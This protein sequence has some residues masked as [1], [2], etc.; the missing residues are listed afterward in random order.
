MIRMI[1]SKSAGHAKAY[2][3]EALAK[4]DYYISDQELA[5]V[6]QGKLATRLGIDGIVN[7]ES[8]FALCENRHPQTGESLTP[9]TKEDRTTGY[10]IN[11]HCPKS[12]SLLHVMSGNDTILKA[13]QDSV[14]E[15]MKEIERDAKTRVRKDGQYDDRD[16]RELV[17]AHFIHQTARPVESRAPD[18]HLHSHCFVFNATWDAQEQKIKAGQF[19]DI[20]RDMPYYQAV[21]H[22]VLSDRLVN[23]GYGIKRTQKSFE[24][25]G[26]AQEVID[27]FSKRTD[28]I[29]RIAKE[30]GITD[31]KELGELGARTR[32]KKQ[33]GTSMADLKKEWQEQIQIIDN[34]KY[35]N[36]VM[37]DKGKHLSNRGIDLTP[38]DCINHAL[39]HGFERASVMQDRRLLET[40]LRHSI[41]HTAVSGIAITNSF[42]SDKRLVRIKDKSKMLCTTK[43]VLSEE[44]RMVD[45]AK[46]G[47]GKVIPLYKEAP[48][49]TLTGQQAA[50]VSHILTTSN[51]V[52]IVRGAA[53]TG[54]TTLMK[55]AVANI[56][57]AGKT[58]TVVAPSAQASRG[59]LKGE[60]FAEAET[61]ARLLVDPKMQERLK[62][63]VLWVDEAGLLGTKDM[64]SLLEITARN[65]ARLILGGDTR[66]HA[67]V[68]RGD[69]LRIL[70]TVAGIKSAEVSKIY[71][72]RNE[73]YKEAV[74]DL[75]KGNI[76]EGFD[77]LV[78]IG[79][80]KAID[81]MKPNEEMVKDYI[82]TIKK[83]KSAIVISPTHAQGDSVTEEIRKHL[84][85]EGMIGKKELEAIKLTSLNFTEA[86]K[87]DARNFKKGWIVQF[88]QNAPGFQRGSMWTVEG[89]TEKGVKIKS[90]SGE[91]KQLPSKHSNTYDVL[92]ENKINLSKGDKVRITRNT[93]DSNKRR[94]N[95][96]QSLEVASVS[97]TGKVILHGP[98]GTTYT[99]DKLFG[100]IAHAHCITSHAAQGKTVDEVFIAQPAATFAATDAKQFYV[101]VSRGRDKAHIY[102]D[103]KEALLQN[104][105]DIGERQSALEL[106]NKFKT[107][108]ELVQQKSVLEYSKFLK[109]ETI[110][111]INKLKGYE[112]EI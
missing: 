44:K 101:S 57:K 36:G 73:Q 11:F 20:K 42:E 105:S 112:P 111:K 21:F 1:Q 43:E 47:Q 38:E 37:L 91:T 108:K 80:I 89:A 8:F 48:A 104:A 9:R 46:Q 83:G 33:K 12:V 79:S 30:K 3:S 78:S 68:I 63:Q 86:E 94:L 61:V 93:S 34:D 92:A 71:R 15:T 58:V 27:L 95:N 53:G 70:N 62:G 39:H 106:V 69:A 51:R 31:A 98:S 26:M 66:Q 77:K 40:A 107:N 110:K 23:L 52:S 67:S 97:K 22:K 29:G 54:K 45:L 74:E 102:T 81:L 103:D 90:S 18:P 72:Q 17:W 109:E 85:K 82:E 35:R 10:D 24:I 75:S 25:E 84:R 87:K 60:G 64:L 88:N 56:E 4:S 28:E 2:F 41:G 5:G 16:T 49:L 32:S 13:F 50:A 7:K 14:T 99:I 59:V 65:N 96:G 6:W 19:R 55:E 76:R 100:H